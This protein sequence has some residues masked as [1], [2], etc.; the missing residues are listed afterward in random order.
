M[1]A[2]QG[3]IATD[4][5]DNLKVG[6]GDIRAVANRGPGRQVKAVHKFGQ[7]VGYKIQEKN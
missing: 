3:T 1:I 2:E 4:L 6:I 5:A 7:G